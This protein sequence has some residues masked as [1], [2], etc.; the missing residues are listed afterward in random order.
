MI[1]YTF[2]SPGAESGQVWSRSFLEPLA[3]GALTQFSSSLLAEIVA[4][5]WYL[6]YDR[7]G[8]SPT[9]KTRV[10]KTIHGRP[11]VN[12]TVSARLD[13]DNAGIE[14][15]AF[16]VDGNRRALFAWQKPGLLGG[17]KLGRGAK[18]ID[19]TLAALQSELPDITAR[20]REWHDK[21]LALRWSQA[22]VLQI[23][24]EIER[25]GAAALLPYFA[26][27]HNLEAAIRRLLDLLSARPATEAM[28]LLAATLGGA[29]AVLEHDM[30]QR[31][32]MLGRMAAAQ[33]QIAAWLRA[34]DFD[35]WA[36]SVPAGDFA[37]AARTF[38]GLYGHRG[39]AE[40][41]VC[42]PRW[43][44]RPALVFHAIQI[45]AANPATATATGAGPVDTLLAAVDG[46]AQ[47]EAGRLVEQVRTLIEMQSRA[48]NAFAYILAATRRWALA[49]G[50]EAMADRRITELDNVFF[51]ELEEMKQMMTGEW[52][53]S[54]RSGIHE[55]ASE[56][57]AHFAAW[58]QAVPAPLIWDERA[59]RAK[60]AALPAAAGQA[61]GPVIR[62]DANETTNGRAILAL[63]QP[64]SGA[65]ILLAAASGY[66]SA[67]GSL[68]DPLAACARTLALPAVVDLGDAFFELATSPRVIVDGAQGKVH[69]E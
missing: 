18:K 55:T 65:A 11:F 56:R 26:V 7:L 21:V 33:P 66:F 5:T 19:E 30:A 35:D 58:Q 16:V 41:D 67:Q 43:N 50:H 42:N 63:V 69:A 23:M 4:R 2:A 32:R 59:V 3:P 36:N 52:N 28:A 25:Y 8:F 37:D 29:E 15:P 57:R 34:G 53:V 64:G 24:E 61:G 60:V 13:A 48:L 38:F 22:E 47:K 17:M 54:D 20:A 49:A 51:Y 44:E 27:R 6:Y 46:K 39:L 45:A 31:I 40:G 9:P 12:L 14:P 1:E 10:V 68:H 62:L